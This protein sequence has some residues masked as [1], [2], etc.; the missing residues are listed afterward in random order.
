MELGTY[1]N[2]LGEYGASSENTAPT[3]NAG[4]DQTLAA[5]I[6]G[7][8][9]GSGTV[10]TAGATITGYQWIAPAGITI[11]G[12]NTANPTFTAPQLNAATTFTFSL[13][14]TD[15]NGLTS[16]ADTVDIIVEAYV[17]P[18][19]LDTTIPVITLTG[20]D[21]SLSVGEAFE[22]PGYSAYD[23][24]DGDLTA[25]VVITGSTDTS[26]PRTGTLSYNVRDE[27]GNNAVTK[28]RNF[29]VVSESELL[30]EI[31]KTKFALSTEKVFYAFSGRGNLDEL[32]FKLNSTNQKIALDNEGC[33]DF[34]ENDI[35]KVSVI[36]DSGEIDS[37]T[38]AVTWSGSSLFIQFGAFS[39]PAQRSSI[40]IV[41]YVGNDDKGIVIAGA[42]LPANIIV[43]FQ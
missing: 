21:I 2:P 28:T 38:S 41:V 37:S 1:P 27:A 36:S 39:S 24:K 9:N 18:V 26:Y 3:A 6:Q 10:T 19:E 5:N 35:T 22:E 20:G 33:F 11:I 31:A 17:P 43:T 14:V 7:Q 12:A 42:G 23:N 13:V 8:L 40:R 25:S 34:S 4:L 15:S 30:A 16:V 32:K 29:S